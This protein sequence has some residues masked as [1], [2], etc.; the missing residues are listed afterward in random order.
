M[1]RWPLASVMTTKPRF[2]G[3]LRSKAAH[4][5]TAL[6]LL[7][8]RYMQHEP[9]RVDFMR[10]KPRDGR[11]LAERWNLDRVGV[12]KDRNYFRIELAL[13]L[14][15]ALRLPVYS[16]A[17]YAMPAGFR[18]N[19]ATP[20]AQYVSPLLQHFNRKSGEGFDW[21]WNLEYDECLADFRQRIMND[22]G[23]CDVRTLPSTIREQL[24]ALPDEARRHGWEL[25]DRRSAQCR[26]AG[27]L[28][29]RLAPSPK[30]FR[31]IAEYDPSL[32]DVATVS[33]SVRLLVELLRVDL[34]VLKPGRP[35]AS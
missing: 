8:D 10:S 31:R 16:T 27:W 6:C 23:I 26:Q 28:F 22:L 32:P 7:L 25:I 5:G 17:S 29:Q 14:P 21:G 3:H 30:G 9:F 20:I 19:G 18:D 12:L 15:E 11:A 33:R 2:P 24:W 13:S 1:R 4:A 35:K 34:P